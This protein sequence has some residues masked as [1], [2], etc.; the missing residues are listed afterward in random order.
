MTQKIETEVSQYVENARSDL[1]WL[2]VVYVAS[3]QFQIEITK[4][5]G[6]L[7]F[8]SEQFVGP[9]LGR[10][11]EAFKKAIRGLPQDNPGGYLNKSAVVYAAAIAEDFLRKAWKPAFGDDPPEEG[12]TGALANQ[13]EQ[14]KGI[15]GFLVDAQ[16]VRFLAH[17]RNKIVHNYGRVDQDFIDKAKSI[18]DKCIWPDDSTFDLQYQLEGPLYL[19]IDE[20]VVPYLHHALDF[21]DVAGEKLK[22]VAAERT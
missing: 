17:L 12:G 15:S 5:A 11:L 13:I 18:R 1:A 3:K 21:V 14:Q 9:G 4:Q 7:L 6:G 19:A 2:A 10:H 20:V 22:Q 8:W 16:H